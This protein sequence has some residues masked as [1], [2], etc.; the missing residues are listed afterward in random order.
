MKIQR[1]QTDQV[2]V[3]DYIRAKARE[4]KL[5]TARGR[6][7]VLC[8]KAQVPIRIVRRLQ[9]AKTIPRWAWIRIDYIMRNPD[10]VAPPGCVVG[11]KL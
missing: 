3:G 1:S 6:Q 10:A 4:W 9:V 5:D 8:K 7:N 11:R 2:D